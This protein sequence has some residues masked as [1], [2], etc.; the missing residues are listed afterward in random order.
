MTPLEW[1]GLPPDADERM[2]K[3]IY[4]QRLR[5]TRPDDDPEGFQQLHAVYQAALEQCRRPVAAGSTRDA[6]IRP[7]A[8]TV[9]TDTP[10]TITSHHDVAPLDI[11]SF[12]DAVIQRAAED[13]P[14]TLSAWLHAQPAL[15][16]LPLKQRV[17]V[18]LLSRLE[19]DQPP[20]QTACF[21]ALLRFFGLDDALTYS[22]PLAL[23][24][25]QR[26]LQLAWELQPDHTEALA[27]R[28]ALNTPAQRQGMDRWLRQLRRPYAPAQ[29]ALTALIP[30]RAHELADF[31]ARLTQKCPEDLPSTFDPRQI[32][33]WTQAI[34]RSQITAP[35]LLASGMRCLA[36]LLCASVLGL[37]LGVLAR[38]PPAL[39]S[40]TALWWVLG[41]TAAL[42]LLWFTWMA[43]LALDSWHA[44]P[45]YQ[46][47][48]WPW[49]NLLLVPLL[50]ASSIA[51][52]SARG[53]IALPWL[54]LIPT[55]W[56]AYR[57]LLRRNPTRLPANFA[58]VMWF[59]MCI[60]ISL[61]ST[62]LDNHQVNDRMHSLPVLLAF[63]ALLFW[64]G[65][66]WCC[67]HRLRVR[68]AR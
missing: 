50:C 27:H 8:T 46:A 68:I 35:R 31:V 52:C 20:M 62:Q 17:G 60:G 25:L 47:V 38:T 23:Q 53:L 26:R 24:T 33:F 11:T 49:L 44:A 66:L 1:F 7:P 3:R 67:Y 32:N 55:V 4:A 45:E 6:A 64:G 51:L 65:D 42:C 10:A 61:L 13:Q 57:R 41:T 37:L 59:A 21:H 14:E 5:G 58:R 18:Y 40:T 9:S 16:S 22:N 56:L 30:E 19:H 48:R 15:W 29:A 2:V 63:A 36:I 12:C 28:L 34:D 54:L 39:L 43:L